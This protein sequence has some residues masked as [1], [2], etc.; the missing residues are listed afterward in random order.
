MVRLAALELI[1]QYWKNT[2]AFLKNINSKNI[3]VRAI[4]R[5]WTYMQWNE[6]F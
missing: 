1:E 5:K 3:C 2:E 6:L 4:N